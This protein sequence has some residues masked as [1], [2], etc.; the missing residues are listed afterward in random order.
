VG[1]ITINKAGD[2]QRFTAEGRALFTMF[3]AEAAL[4]IENAR[5]FEEGVRR[6]ERLTSILD[7]NRRIATSTDL[8]HLVGQITQQ[9][10][11]LVRASG[12]RVGLRRGDHLVFENR[13]DHGVVPAGTIQ[14]PLGVNLLG[15]VVRQDQAIVVTDLKSEARILPVYRQRFADA[16]LH[17]AAFVP[18]RGS[19]E[20]LGVLYVTSRQRRQFT[21]DEVEVLTTY[22]E[23]VAIAIEHARLMTA[24]EE[25]TAALEHANANLRREITEHQCTALALQESEARYREL[26]ENANDIVYTHDLQG[27]FTSINRAAERI[28]GYTRDEALRMSI[29]DVVAPEYLEWVQQ[30]V[31]SQLA[32][33]STGTYELDIFTKHNERVTLEVSTRLIYEGDTPVGVQGIGRNITERKRLEAQLLQAQKMEAV[34]T[35]AG[36][37]AHDFNNILAAVLGY[38]ELAL[39][40]TPRHSASWLHLQEVLTAANRAKEL[41]RQILAFSRQIEHKRKPL[42]LRLLI[43]EA[44]TMLRASLPSTIELKLHLAEAAGPVLADPIQMHQVLLNLCSNA[45]H[46]MR[47]TGGILEIDLEAVPADA[48]FATQ[49]PELPMGP[50]VRLTV[51]DTGHGIAPEIQKRIFEPFFTTKPP[52]EGTGMGLAL[53]HGIVASH[54]G[55]LKVQSVMGQGTRCEITLPQVMD[56]PDEVV[57]EDDGLPTRSG[58]ILFVDDESSLARVGQEI[59]GRL[60]YEVMVRTSSVE[61]LEAFRAMPQRF[62]LVITD[63]TMP[64]MTGEMLARELRRIRPDIPIIL[65]TGFSHLMHAEKAQAMGIDAF[66]MKPILTQEL[67]QAIQQVLAQRQAQRI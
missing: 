52:G 9:A 1:V 25:R 13:H 22:A 7:I 2:T 36:G 47:Q 15:Q 20:T 14:I 11:R 18:I 10:C 19:R 30:M 24:V 56:Q 29:A 64:T 23:Q 33:T 53:V 21:A 38:T 31:A 17:S 45:E 34:G 26:F 8:E 16:G 3:A 37:I 48:Q 41:V 12:A 44:L 54:G 32:T 55:V 46:A 28:T 59:L 35:L 66:L 4:A 62:D 49:H 57:T 67:A 50:Y 27:R 58:Y 65:C 63:Q 6:Q 51:C 5:L 39:Y 60:G 40:D 43:Q 61:A 42:Q